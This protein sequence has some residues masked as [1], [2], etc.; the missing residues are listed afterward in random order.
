MCSVRALRRPAVQQED[1]R[2]IGPEDG[3][4]IILRYAGNC[5]ADD[6]ASYPRKFEP[7]VA[8][9]ASYEKHCTVHM[10]VEEIYDILFHVFSQSL[11]DSETS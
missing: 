4:T 10:L 11:H 1:N 2:L 5:T 7:S 8:S 3:G 9:L 6:T